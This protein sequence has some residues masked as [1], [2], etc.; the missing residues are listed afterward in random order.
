M[1]DHEEELNELVPD[2]DS[3]PVI[4]DRDTGAGDHGLGLYLSQMGSI[5]LLSHEQEMELTWRLDRLRKR[6]CHAVF[7]NWDVLARVVETFEGISA[8]TQPLDRTVDVFPGQ[9]MTAAR[10][11]TRMP[12]HLR[13]LRGLV[14]E[15]RQPGSTSTAARRRLRKA[16]RLAEELSPRIELVGAWSVLHEQAGTAPALAGLDEVVRKRRDLYLKA[17]KTLAEANLRLVV[18]Q[19][20]RF[21]GRGLPF[22]DLIQEG[23]SGLMRTV[24]KFD[25]ALG[26]KF[27]TYATWWVRQGLTRAL[28]DTARVVRVP[29]HQV[30]VLGAIERTRR[31][32]LGRLGREPTAEELGQVLGLAVE[33][34]KRLEAAGRQPVSLNETIQNQEESQSA[35]QALLADS[36]P[37]PRKPWTS[38]CSRNES[39]SCCAVWHRA[40]GK[41]SSCALVC[42]TANRIPWM[43][44]PIGWG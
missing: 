25:P 4:E 42:G 28:A 21:R 31:E 5:P 10:I 27:G 29:S 9:G 17:R 32:L 3:A 11:R 24:D 1:L 12:G 44:W 39:P 33:E 13:Q 37:T 18:S 20:K 6:Y 41:S 23:N 15:G 19:A 43:R 35:Y 26:F 2:E 8:G 16:V 36:A 30:R 38:V 40:I 14:A 22:A 34:I 7:W